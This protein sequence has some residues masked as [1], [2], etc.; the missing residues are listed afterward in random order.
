MKRV[1]G[2]D[3]SSTTIGVCLLKYDDNKIELEH[4]EFFKPSKK[5]DVFERLQCVRQY[6]FDK[7]SELK[8]DAAALE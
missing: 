7:I 5:G 2:L 1:M 6:I 8:P 3:A 4:V